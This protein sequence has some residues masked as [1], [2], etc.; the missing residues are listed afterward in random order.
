MLAGTLLRP[1]A[2]ERIALPLAGACLLPLAAFAVHP[3]LP[4]AIVLLALTGLCAAYALGMD[5]WFV[6]EV[7]ADMR[8]RAMSLMGAGLMTLQGIGMTA[9][10]AFAEWA[11][12]F[13]VICG[14]GVLGT[15]SVLAVIR[16]VHRTRLPLPAPVPTPSP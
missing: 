12:P 9:G 6:D 1:A 10:G 7:P 5:K 8:G 2:R 16:T 11:P 4:L 13:A 3:P 14:G 15:L